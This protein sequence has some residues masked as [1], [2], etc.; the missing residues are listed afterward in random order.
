MSSSL[1]CRCLPVLLLLGAGLLPSGLRADETAVP[2][3]KPVAETPEQFNQRM[4]WWR[5]ARFGMFIHWGP[6]SLK[7]TEIG[8][9]RDS[10]GTA[11]Y[12]N[13]YK[14]FNPVKFDA[15]AWVAVAKA[16]GMKYIVLTTR[17]HDGFCLWDTKYTDYNIMNSPFKRDVTKELA[18][19]CK[20]Q[21]IV[22]CSYYSICD[23]WHPLYPGGNET[24]I[25]GKP[26]ADMDKFNQYLK[27]QL[28]EQIKNYGPLGLVW[29][30]GEWEAPWTHE[31]GVD[32][33]N[34]LRKLQPNLIVN[35][36]VDKGRAGMKGD[37]ATGFVGDY[38]TPEQRIG[39]FNME[40]P[41]ETCMTICNQWAWKPDD[42]MKSLKECVQSLLCTVGGD[43]NLL[44]NVGPQP[45]GQIEARQVE[46]LKEM[47]AYVQKYGSGIYGTRGGPFKPGKWGVSTRHGNVITLFVMTW[48]KN[49]LLHLPLVDCKLVGVKTLSGG[50][51]NL[52][53]GDRSLMVSLEEKD[54]DPIASVIELMF[55]G[56]VLSLPAMDVNPRGFCGVA[57]GCAA[58]ASNVFNKQDQEYGPQKAFD[59]DAETRWA[60]DEGVK[61]AWLEVDLGAPQSIRRI[62]ID[63]GI[64]ARVLQFEVQT[65]EGDAW[66]TVA[67]GS[68]IGADKEIIL[69]APTEGRIFRLNI[70]DATDGPTIQDFQL[71]NN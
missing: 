15:D 71:F 25:K 43:G 63:E 46:R 57:V 62:V 12:D 6:V 11:V 64:W 61:K 50:K 42:K 59:G 9:S 39:G 37:T 3:V 16:A 40:R 69:A 10:V 55:D 31:R 18:A 4:A 20:K 65:K 35:N 70:L 33:Y 68:T 21:G 36:R 45:D 54:R 5:D 23:W 67:T 1:L 47:G 8:W 41:W 30:D 24:G 2:G 34:Y 48:P 13:L 49:G 51:A 32:L 26:H 19:A 28:A 56:P 60:T 17:H 14:Q 58:T 22:Y 38:D 44:F 66:Q 7:G 53:E 27:D 52:D 29:F